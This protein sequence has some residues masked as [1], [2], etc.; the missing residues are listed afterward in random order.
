MACSDKSCFLKSKN[1]SEFENFYEL[2]LLNYVIKHLMEPMK[3]MM[4]TKILKYLLTE[5]IIMFY[6]LI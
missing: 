5:K 3:I 2:K 6:T 1:Q 4:I